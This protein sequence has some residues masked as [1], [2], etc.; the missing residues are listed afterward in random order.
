MTTAEFCRTIRTFYIRNEPD[1]SKEGSPNK[2]PRLLATF[3]I[4][5]RYNHQ[6]INPFCIVLDTGIEHIG[7]LYVYV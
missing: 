5:L 6:I 1:M 3:Q 4:G 7:D 2:K